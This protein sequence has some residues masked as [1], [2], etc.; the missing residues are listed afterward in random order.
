MSLSA[1]TQRDLSTFEQGRLNT[2]NRDIR[3]SS[4]QHISDA[5]FQ[6]CRKLQENYAAICSRGLT[7]LCVVLEPT[8]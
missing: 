3:A 1:T 2:C 5:A 6:S 4:H 7:S 8:L